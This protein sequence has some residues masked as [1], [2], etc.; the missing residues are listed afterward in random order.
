M[1]VDAINI[2]PEIM[3]GTPVFKG[4]RVPVKTLFQ[5]LETESLEE[6]L[7]NFPSVEKEQALEVLEFAGTLITSEIILDE[8]F[9]G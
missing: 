5:W 4:T 6:F 1:K 3:S 9:I 8:S 2:D 7:D